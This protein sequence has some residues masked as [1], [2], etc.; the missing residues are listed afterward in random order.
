MT[1]HEL[2]PEREADPEQVAR[3]LVHGITAD[4]STSATWADVDLARVILDVSAKI[5]GLKAAA[6]TVIAERMKAAQTDTFGDFVEALPDNERIGVGYLM[7]VVTKLES[8][9]EAD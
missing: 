4:E 7:W 8:P 5:H 1:V 3:L 2:R 6:G 9:L